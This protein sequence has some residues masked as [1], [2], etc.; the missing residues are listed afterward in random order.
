MKRILFLVLVVVFAMTS[1]DHV[2]ANGDE[3]PL[4]TTPLLVVAAPT[5][6]FQG[7]TVRVEISIQNLA[8]KSQVQNYTITLPGSTATNVALTKNDQNAKLQKNKRTGEWIVVWRNVRLK[9]GQTFVSIILDVTLTDKAD[10]NM[11]LLKVGET[12]NWILVKA[13]AFALEWSISAPTTVKVGT[14]FIYSFSAHNPSTRPLDFN[15][16]SIL[17]HYC[18]VGGLIVSAPA[19]TQQGAAYDDGAYYQYSWRGTVQP[20]E[21][22]TWKFGLTAQSVPCQWPSKYEWIDNNNPSDSRVLNVDIIQ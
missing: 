13:P 7:E 12:E 9:K 6:G 22:L 14:V 17:A 16:N 11:L 19:G 15:I 8:Q 2:H 5:E 1:F 18:T 10:G 21:T 3:K 20:G 4:L